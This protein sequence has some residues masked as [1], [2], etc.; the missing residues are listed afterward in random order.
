MCTGSMYT[1]DCIQLESE[2]GRCYT[3]PAPYKSNVSSFGLDQAINA[4]TPNLAFGCRLYEEL[5]VARNVR[6][7]YHVRE[8]LQV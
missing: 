2:I 1:V 6:F 3:I 7:E 4:T 8:L 5:C